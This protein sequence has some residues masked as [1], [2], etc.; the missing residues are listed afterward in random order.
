[1]GDQ[2]LKLDELSVNCQ[3]NYISAI[4]VSITVFQCST[5]GK[6][7]RAATNSS[8]GM[9]LRVNGINREG[10]TYRFIKEQADDLKFSRNE[11]PKVRAWILTDVPSNDIFCS[12]IFS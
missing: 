6:Q 8:I 7:K 11:C 1:M 10:L 4:R 12:H 3:I 5:S 9:D 2:Y